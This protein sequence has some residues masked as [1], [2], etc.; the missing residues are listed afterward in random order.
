MDVAL[1]LTPAR[2]FSNPSLLVD[3]STTLTNTSSQGFDN[4]LG[5][6]FTTREPQN[7]A[8]QSKFLVSDL[9]TT[10]TIQEALGVLPNN[11]SHFDVRKDILVWTNQEPLT[12]LQFQDSPCLQ[13][14]ARV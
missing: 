1:E 13:G 2:A 12:N 6:P 5:G 7:T 14:P 11:T 8:W 4:V 10:L 9:E 3:G